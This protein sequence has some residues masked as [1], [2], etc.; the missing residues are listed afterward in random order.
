MGK[1]GWKP[2]IWSAICD[3]CGFEYNSDQIRTEWTGLKVCSMCWEARH[4]QD[5]IRVQ[6][7]KIVPPWT[8]P[9]A[10]DAF[11]QVC[12]QCTSSA[13]A[14]LATAGCAIV[15]NEPS[16]ELLDTY[17]ACTPDGWEWPL[18][19]PIVTGMGE[20]LHTFQT[21]PWTI[22]LPSGIQPGE[23]ILVL[24]LTGDSGGPLTAAGYTLVDNAYSGGNNARQTIY[25]RIATGA[26]TLT[27]SVG[28]L[29][30]VS[31]F[32]WRISGAGISDVSVLKDEITDGSLNC[33]SPPATGI[34]RPFLS[35]IG[36]QV[37]TIFPSEPTGA[38]ISSYPTGYSNT[39][40][41][42]NNTSSPVG[43][44]AVAEKSCA[45]GNETPGAI[46]LS[47]GAW[48]TSTTIVITATP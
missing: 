17:A 10:E 36:G 8:R 22:T 4:P 6:P 40:F 19:V 42:G 5:L 20:D 48:L 47:A 28:A 12:D 38:L 39:R 41:S 44:L 14:G 35:L 18:N 13:Y 31:A 15:G 30:W 7:E 16:H 2:G 25:A 43:G 1:Q 24:A 32:S 46:V 21:A 27:T 34:P 33:L 11:A 29:G 26:D 9:E 37:G 23:L 3:R 45:A